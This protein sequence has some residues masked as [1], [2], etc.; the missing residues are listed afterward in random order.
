MQNLADMAFELLLDTGLAESGDTKTLPLWKEMGQEN[1]EILATRIGQDWM[2]CLMVPEIPQEVTDP[3]SFVQKH[4]DLL[5][6][7]AQEKFDSLSTNQ[8]LH[9]AS[10]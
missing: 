10:V 7:M 2:D 3:I 4:S 5:Q 9:E 8:E 6:I 1:A